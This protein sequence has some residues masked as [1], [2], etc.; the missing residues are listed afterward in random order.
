VCPCGPLGVEAAPDRTSPRRWLR[1]W[2]SDRGDDPRR[3]T[4]T[5]RTTTRQYLRLIINNIII[6]QHHPTTHPLPRRVGSVWLCVAAN[7]RAVAQGLTE[8]YLPWETLCY[9]INSILVLATKRALPPW[10]RVKPTACK[11]FTPPARRNG[12]ATRD[13]LLEW[14]KNRHGNT[15]KPYDWA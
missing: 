5:S 9:P 10:H 3:P 2:W 13:S 14:N 1:A 4:V 8:G 6:I 11:S 7:I 12:H 15:Q